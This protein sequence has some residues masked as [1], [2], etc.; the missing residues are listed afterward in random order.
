MKEFINKLSELQK[1]LLLATCISLI[2]IAVS[3]VGL[4]YSRPG[5]LIGVS[6]GSIVEII[7]IILL[8]KG[9]V[10]VL[11][12]QK[13]ALFLVFHALRMILFI[14][15]VALLVILQY[16]VE[17]EAFKYSFWGALIAYTPMQIIVIIVTL[18]HKGNDV[19]I[20]GK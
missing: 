18:F 3:C 16:K 2:S 8:Y 5:W 17:I 19:G 10:L 9:N 12:G 4:A 1:M 7:N 20:E 11:K 14:G 6:L 13:A 15:L